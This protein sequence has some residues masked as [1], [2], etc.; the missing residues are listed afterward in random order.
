MESPRKKKKRKT[1]PLMKRGN[2]KSDEGWKFG[3]GRACLGLR[4]LA[5]E[6]G[7]TLIKSVSKIVLYFQIGSCLKKTI[8][9]CKQA[10]A[11]NVI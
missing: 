3:R 10:F 2:K 9:K 1:S 7:N 11:P 4:G 6:N 5:K 8:N